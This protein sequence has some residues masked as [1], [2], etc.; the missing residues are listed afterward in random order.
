[1]Y[2]GIGLKTARGSGTNGYVTKNFAH[3]REGARKPYTPNSFDHVS[4]PDIKKA[5][6]QI[7]MHEQ[8]KKIESRLYDMRVR[9]EEKGN[10]TAQQID[11]MI[12]KE[13]KELTEEAEH[14]LHKSQSRFGFAKKLVAQEREHYQNDKSG[15]ESHEHVQ[16]RNRK[17]TLLAQ[18]LGINS[19]SH[20]EGAAFNKELQEKKKHERMQHRETAAKERQAYLIKRAQEEEKMVAASPE[21][22]KSPQNE[23][24][25][26]QASPSPRASPKR[27][28]R[29]SYSS[30]SD[31]SE[32]EK[33]R[34]RK[35]ARHDSRE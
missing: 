4:K 17:N 13:R 12:T 7:L 22:T 23:D 27:K 25:K 32:D 8:R 16:A 19:E 35:R 20:V 34:S 5:N 18:A 24:A 26:K 11:E 2:N 9:L 10:Y 15:V 29:R 14:N 33:R 3:V 31:D 28:R 1:M 21:P 6:S 30:S